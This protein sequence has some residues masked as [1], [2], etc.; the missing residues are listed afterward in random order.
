MSL[1]P[2]H[3]LLGAILTFSVTA[4]PAPL[5]AAQSGPL[6]S[7]AGSWKGGGTVRFEGGKSER[8]S[9][10]GHYKLSSA[11]SALGIAIRCASS[12]AK[13]DLRSALAY[14]GG[15]VSGTWEE[16]TFNASGSVS[17]RASSGRLNLAIS[18]GLS[19]S[20]LVAFTGSAQTV[21]INTTG[22]G[23]HGV[24]INLSRN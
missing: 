22:T 24:S 9:C 4:G 11:G 21:S 7:L 5:M 17:G 12:S 1:R 16:R 15:R 23:L 20:M 10:R 13:F 6:T 19:G 14:G 3:V 8:L 2:T 18:G